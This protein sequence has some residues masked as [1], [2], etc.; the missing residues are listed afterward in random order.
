MARLGLPSAP[1]ACGCGVVQLLLGHALPL[2][3]ASA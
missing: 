3:L 2:D 1:S